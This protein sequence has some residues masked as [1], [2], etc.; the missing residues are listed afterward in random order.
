MQNQFF[1]C[2]PG[3][4]ES[5][6]AAMDAPAGQPARALHGLFEVADVD[7]V[8]LDMLAEA[9]GL[10]TP[11]WLDPQPDDPDEDL[12]YVVAEV[13]PHLVDALARASAADLRVVGERWLAL[14][15]A[16]LAS[17]PAYGGVL[18]DYQRREMADWWPALEA[19][20][21]LSRAAR[22]HGESVFV[23]MLHWSRFG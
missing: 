21:A 18:P 13:A 4:V 17:I 20:A 23:R 7:V 6:L 10:P 5:A 15:M 11:A 16:D 2:G 1:R 22:D 9:A 8:V 19:I 12:G 14:W 3:E